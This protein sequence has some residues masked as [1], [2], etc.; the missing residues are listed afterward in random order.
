MSPTSVVAGSTGNTLTF[1]YTVGAS[2][3]PASPGRAPAD[4]GADCEW[5]DGPDDLRGQRQG[6]CARRTRCS[7]T[8][9]LAVSGSNIQVSG[10]SSTGCG[11]GDTITITYSAAAGSVV[12]ANPFTTSTRQSGSSGGLAN[13]A[14]QPSVN[15]TA[16]AVNTT[17]TITN[18]A[19][20]GTA[21]L[22]GQAYPVNVGVA[23]ASGP[24]ARPG[25]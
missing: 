21:T 9:T 3:G 7:G 17:T 24:R 5:L 23:A 22:V 25:R 12:G 18:S 13:I 20:L 6:D 8:P 15:V 4:R 14:T 11:S 16:P 10:N 1:V 19:A 2:G